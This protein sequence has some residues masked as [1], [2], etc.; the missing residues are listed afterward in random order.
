LVFA[1]DPD[2][3][4][5]PSAHSIVRKWR[6][7]SL[8]DEERILLQDK[9]FSAEEHLKSRLAGKLQLVESPTRKRSP[10]IGVSKMLALNW[11]AA[12]RNIL[13]RFECTHVIISL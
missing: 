8:E 2:A 12:K 4:G 3:D 1:A 9:V 10:S 6:A 11:W 13:L 5:T 7:Q